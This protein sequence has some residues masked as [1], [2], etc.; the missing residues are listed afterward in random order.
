MLLVKLNYLPEQLPGHKCQNDKSDYVPF[1]IR[2]YLFECIL[3]SEQVKF[4]KI[5]TELKE[6]GMLF[7]KPY[8]HQVLESDTLWNESRTPFQESVLASVLALS[9]NGTGQASI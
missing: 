1:W 5:V 9:V 6:V 8:S 3:L 7:L 4:S 2:V